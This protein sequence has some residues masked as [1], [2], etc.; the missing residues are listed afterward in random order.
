MPCECVAKSLFIGEVPTWNG[1]GCGL[2]FVW[3]P[4]LWQSLENLRG[5]EASWDA[6]VD[7]P[8]RRLLFSMLWGL[9]WEKRLCTL[10]VLDLEE[11]GGGEVTNAFCPWSQHWYSGLWI[12]IQLLIMLS[13]C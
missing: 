7:V 3:E 8:P 12:W 2:D 1:R 13:S 4:V 10:Q 6:L 5:F 11:G 9:K